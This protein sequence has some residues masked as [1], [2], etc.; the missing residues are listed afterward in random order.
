MQGCTLKRKATQDSWPQYKVAS[1][2]GMDDV[3]FG[4]VWKHC[5]SVPDS[6]AFVDENYNMVMRH[7]N[8]PRMWWND[9]SRRAYGGALRIPSVFKHSPRNQTRSLKFLKVGGPGGERFSKMGQKR[10]IDQINAPLAAIVLCAT[11]RAIITEIV[12]TVVS[13][14]TRR[15]TVHLMVWQRRYASIDPVSPPLVFYQGNLNLTTAVDVLAC[16]FSDDSVLFKQVKPYNHSLV[17]AANIV[18]GMKLPSSLASYCRLIPCQPLLRALQ[19]TN[20]SDVVRHE[21]AE[22]RGGIATPEVLPHLK[23]WMARPDA[24]TVVRESCL[25]AT[26]MW[27][28]E[29]SS[30]FQYAKA[31]R[32]TQ[33][34]G[35]SAHDRSCGCPLEFEWTIT[36]SGHMQPDDTSDD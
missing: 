6:S 30:E 7:C 14:S 20:E 35:H 29:N 36:T 19:D 25:V 9:P 23:E 2:A 18:P 16:G 4:Y 34:S 21:A 5:K 17:V 1:G 28:F 24:P 3:S 26:D 32:P 31:G 11:A 10:I 15:I 8:T 33:H 27:E 22:A 12:V 13:E